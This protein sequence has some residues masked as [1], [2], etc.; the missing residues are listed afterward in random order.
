[1]SVDRSY[2]ENVTGVHGER[3]GLPSRRELL[4]AGVAAIVASGA[5]LLAPAPACAVTTQGPLYLSAINDGGPNATAITSATASTTFTVSQTGT[6]PALEVVTSANGEVAVMSAE[7]AGSGPCVS[8]HVSNPQNAEG[9]L[10]VQHDG[11]GEAIHAGNSGSSTDPVVRAISVGG[12]P[13]VSAIVDNVENYDA[14][15]SALTN[16]SSTGNAVMAVID[17]ADSGGAAVLAQT[18]GMGSGVEA[19]S[20]KGYGVFAIGTRAPICLGIGNQAGAPMDPYHNYGEI[21]MDNTGVL[22]KVVTEGQPADEGVVQKAPEWV[23][24][25]S[26]VPITPVR[27]IDTRTGLG[28][29]KGALPSAKVYN[30]KNIVGK[31]GIPTKAVG[32][33]GNLTMVAATGSLDGL[34]WM[35]IL[36]ATRAAGSTYNPPTSSVNAAYNCLATA[37]HF[38]VSLGQGAYAGQISIVTN[39][40][41]G[42]HAVV[43]ITAYIA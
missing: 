15:I 28:G 6:G 13:A 40:K 22:F 20:D 39:A 14:A 25:R 19:R 4:I 36:P 29:V 1:M 7:N 2:H 33:V 9:A 17:N 8:V 21:Y 35:A 26:T 34:A 38:T 16:N 30:F 32:L 27:I 5:S 31:N 12:G 42:L 37:N 18:N 3:R 23:P 10:L 11:L 24:F 41:I 43:D